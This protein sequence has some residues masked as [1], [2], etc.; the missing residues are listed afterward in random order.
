MGCVGT[1]FARLADMLELNTARY[2]VYTDGADLTLA[3]IQ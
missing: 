2:S 3:A 1:P